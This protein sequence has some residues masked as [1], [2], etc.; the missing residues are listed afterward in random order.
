[1]LILYFFNY[2][3]DSFFVFFSSKKD[4]I[5]YSEQLFFSSWKVSSSIN[6][7]SNSIETRSPKETERMFT[8]GLIFVRKLNPLFCFSSHN[9]EGGLGK[10][11]FYVFFSLALLYLFSGISNIRLP[12]FKA[13][14]NL[15]V[16]PCVVFCLLIFFYTYSLYCLQV[17][18][19]F[20]ILFSRS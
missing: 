1:M 9:S 11:E 13:P 19:L 5:C 20:L 15:H 4:K 18:L 6:F 7:R 10:E 16:T 17:T 14:I 2:S 8:A 3:L 12:F